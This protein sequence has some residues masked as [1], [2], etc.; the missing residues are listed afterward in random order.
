M[1]LRALLTLPHQE[2]VVA[3]FRVLLVLPL[4]C[5]N[6]P[7][8]SE[9]W[10]SGHLVIFY[11]LPASETGTLDAF[12]TLTEMDSKVNIYNDLDI[13]ILRHDGPGT[14]WGA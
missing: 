7:A 2:R 6:N 10:C 3:F 9:L 14:S 1:F 12:Y 8:T 13:V 4:H 11:R 5:G